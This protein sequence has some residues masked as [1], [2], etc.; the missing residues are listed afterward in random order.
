M[1]AIAPPPTIAIFPVMAIR[2]RLLCLLCLLDPLQPESAALA[3][4]GRGRGEILGRS[5]RKSYLRSGW[6]LLIRCCNPEGLSACTITDTWRC[7]REAALTVSVFVGNH[8][9]AEQRIG[10][11]C[12]NVLGSHAGFRGHQP[13]RN[14]FQSRTRWRLL[15]SVSGSTLETGFS[16]FNWQIPRHSIRLRRTSVSAMVWR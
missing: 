2:T 11:E 10:N 8:L 1:M 14:A 3:P 9:R 6:S 15:S 7:S 13:A 12:R 5:L 4:V 16:P